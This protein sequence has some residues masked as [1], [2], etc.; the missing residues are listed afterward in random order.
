MKRLHIH[1][2]VAD[3]E[4][5]IRFYSTLF[6]FPPT[7]H[8]A[9]YAKWMLDDP[10]VNFAISNRGAKTGLDHLGLQAENDKEIAELKQRLD[11]AGS[12]V[13]EQIGTGCC[14]AI[15]DKYW[16]RDPQGIPWE[17]FHSL[18]EIPVFGEDPDLRFK[19]SSTSTCCAPE[20]ASES[21][22]CCG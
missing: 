8:K 15:S 17:S 18:G 19:D 3:L 6:G 10:R 20:L 7:V 21:S 9:D 14:Y 16:T 12:P 22:G 1:L 5:N 4:E 13:A 11:Q 2:A